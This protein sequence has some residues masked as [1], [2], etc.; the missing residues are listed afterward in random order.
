[1]WRGSTTSNSIDL[2]FVMPPKDKIERYILQLRDCVKQRECESYEALFFFTSIRVGSQVYDLVMML[3]EILNRNPAG[4]LGIEAAKA[5]FAQGRQDSAATFE[6]LAQ[7]TDLNIE[8]KRFYQH[9]ADRLK[10]L[11]PC[12]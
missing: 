9:F 4:P 12:D 7:R 1:M 5:L 8:R 2:N 10:K 6:K 3:D 11:G